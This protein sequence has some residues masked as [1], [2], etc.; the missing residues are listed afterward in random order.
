VC[1]TNESFL[2]SNSEKSDFLKALKY[3]EQ[4]GAFKPSENNILLSG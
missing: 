3:F 2:V 1:K 4:I